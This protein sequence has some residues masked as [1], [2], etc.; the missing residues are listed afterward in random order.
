MKIRDLLAVES[1]D[2]NGKATG[3][4]DVLNQCV[5]LMA[6]SGKIADVEKYR[7]GVFATED[8]GTTEIGRAHV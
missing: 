4:T 2:L 8:E 1:I 6:K 5:D 7:K 3:K